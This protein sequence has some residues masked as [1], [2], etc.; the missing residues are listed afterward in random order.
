MSGV[1]VTRYVALLHLRTQT[2]RSG[3]D[4]LL[5]LPGAERL[6]T[7]V[8]LVELIDGDEFRSDLGGS[9]AAL[10]EIRQQYL[11][12]FSVLYRCTEEIPGS[13]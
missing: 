5:A 13:I 12:S 11:P 2:A 6:V 8:Q 3:R 7:A 4:R 1:R 9:R 10:R